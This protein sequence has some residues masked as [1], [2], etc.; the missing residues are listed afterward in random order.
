VKMVLI[1]YEAGIDEDL[2]S[3]IERLGVPGWTKLTGATGTGR[4]GNRFGTQIWPGTNNLL[5]MALP[6]DRVDSV[7][8]VLNEL[9]TSYLKPPALQVFVL[10]T[11]TRQ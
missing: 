7:I 1:V 3:V 6:E 10:P 8:E 2:Q 9:K 11:E 5:M 4:H